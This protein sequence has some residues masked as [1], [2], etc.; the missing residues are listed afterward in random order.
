MSSRF[1]ALL[2]LLAAALTLG[3][4][5]GAGTSG[6]LPKKIDLTNPAA[7]DAYLSSLGVD[8]STVVRQVGLNNYAG[9]N[10]P[11]VGWNC[12]TSTKVD[13]TLKEFASKSAVSLQ[14]LHGHVDWLERM[15]SAA[16]AMCLS[17]ARADESAAERLGR[18]E[19]MLNAAPPAPQPGEPS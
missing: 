18:L 11:G 12:T 1:V 16:E 10:C 14:S 7:V 8:P 5:A 15:A 3:G 13:A 6:Q 4:S 19:Q 9:P 17:Y 2:A